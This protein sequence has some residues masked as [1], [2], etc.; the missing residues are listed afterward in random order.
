SEGT[1]VK[2]IADGRVILSDWLQ[3]YG[4]LVVVE[5]GKGDMR[6]YG[7]KQSALV[8]VGAKVREGQPI[9]LVCTIGGQGRPSLY[10]E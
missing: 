9:S 7:Y 1:E 5:H 4:L 6:L 3:G 8:R 2:A 10:L